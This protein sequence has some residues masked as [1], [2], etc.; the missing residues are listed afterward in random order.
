MCIQPEKTYK[1]N[2]EDK[3]EETDFSM[4][5]AKATRYT[6]QNN[7]VITSLPHTTYKK[8]IS[9]MGQRSKYTASPSDKNMSLTLS[10]TE[11]SITPAVQ[12][13]KQ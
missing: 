7:K 2:I 9:K 12:P 13:T 11:L 3:K 1:A 8:I 10:N 5:D 6:D 4:T